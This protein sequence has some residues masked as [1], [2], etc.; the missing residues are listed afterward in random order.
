M[1]LIR[2]AA[3]A[4]LETL[5]RNLRMVG[6][7]TL[8][9]TDETTEETRA[10]A[11]LEK[12]TLLTQNGD[13]TQFAALAASYKVLAKGPG[14]QLREVLEKFSQLDS[15]S[16]GRGFYTRCLQC[17][18]SLLPVGGHVVADR[19]PGSVLLAHTE[20]FFCSRCERVYWKGDHYHRMRE[21]V[22]EVIK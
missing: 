9:Q 6:Y 16:K 4:G 2:F 14:P 13:D 19:I 1:N 22:A 15:V 11:H 3:E 17:N 12:R 7:D 10:I 21:W 20:F 5:A 8:W 18:F